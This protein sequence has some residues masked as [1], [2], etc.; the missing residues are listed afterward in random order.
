[1]V[2]DSHMADPPLIRA[3]ESRDY[4]RLASIEAAIDPSTSTTVDWL[5]ERD[6]TRN[7]DHLHARLVAEHDGAVVGY[8]QVGHMWW[9]FHPRHFVMRLNVEPSHQGRGV[10]ST[11][12]TRL[13]GVL[14]DWN[15]EMLATDTR[16]DR[17]AAVRFLEQRG[18]TERNRRWESRL[19]LDEA[20]LD[21]RRTLPVGFDVR[22]YEQEY[23]VR[24]DRLAKELHELEMDAARAEPAYEP[25][26]EMVFEQFVANELDSRSFLP[27]GAFLAFDGE[28]LVGVSR[29]Q[30]ERSRPD[31]LHVGFTGVHPDYHGRGIA[32]ALKVRTI[33][34]ARA[35]GF[36]DIRTENDTRNVPMLRI[37]EAL[38][39]RRG[40]AQIF[41]ERKDF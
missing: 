34:Y 5:R 39:F 41:F 26:S 40:I 37:N 28:R 8:G 30:R 19:V 27:D 33:E 24:G 10:G 1:V 23:A 36:H 3:F 18:F 17:P 16:E 29:L 38:G 14:S 11:L 32:S 9:A 25:G 20:R 6:Q 21:R 4:D 22:T 2:W 35:H 12:F 31:A 15:P 7:P 13:L